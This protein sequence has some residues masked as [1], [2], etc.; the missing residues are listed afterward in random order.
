MTL[1]CV[2]CGNILSEEEAESCAFPM[3]PPSCY[4]CREQVWE[5]NEYG[6]SMWPS[7][8]Y[9][10]AVQMNDGRWQTHDPESNV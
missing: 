10:H 8:W 5:E 4:D 2:C 7:D 9:G 1:R 3:E 6:H